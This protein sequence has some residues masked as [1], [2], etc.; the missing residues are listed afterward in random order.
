MLALA[1][2][3]AWQAL[4]RRSSAAPRVET[5]VEVAMLTPLWRAVTGAL[6]LFAGAGLLWLAYDMLAR[7]GLQIQSLSQLWLFA[8]AVLAPA[9]AVWAI[10]RAF[11][12]QARV[13]ASLLVLDQ[14]RRKI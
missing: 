3:A 8:A 13:E 9:V 2:L 6:R 10:E 14:R 5:V 1:A 4:R 7:T 12:A 11:V